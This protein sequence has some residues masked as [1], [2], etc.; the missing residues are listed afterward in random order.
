MTANQRHLKLLVVLLLLKSNL[1][2]RVKLPKREKRMIHRSKSS[3]LNGAN[4][5]K[6]RRR[7][8]PVKSGDILREIA[9]EGAVKG[10]DWQ[11][12]PLFLLRKEQTEEN[13]QRKLKQLEKKVNRMRVRH[14]AQTNPDPTRE[15]A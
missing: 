14:P 6:K 7:Y 13:I 3:P 15:K 4:T 2:L 8:A 11:V 9:E 5:M 10:F 12:P 1:F